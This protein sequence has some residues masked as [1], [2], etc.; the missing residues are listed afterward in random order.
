M[1]RRK[2][3]AQAWP[4]ALAAAPPVFGALRAGRP[5]RARSEKMSPRTE[6]VKRAMLAMQRDAWEQGTAAQALLEMGETE[7]VILMAKEAA[8]RQTPDG[9]LAVL[10]CFGGVTDPAANG[11][12][13]LFAARK[14]GDPRLFQAA[15]KMLSYLLERAP[16]RADGTLYH[17]SDKKQVWIDSLYMAPPFLA[18]AGRPDEAVRQVEGIRRV[19]WNPEA[20]LFSQI[21]DDDRGEFERKDFWGVGNGWAAA[22]MTR[23]IRALPETM[24]GEKKALAGHV[25]EVIDG[26]LRRQRDDGLFHDVLDRP[27]TFVETNLAQMLAYSIYRGI[28]GGWLDPALQKPADRMREAARGKVDAF[29][30]VQGVCGSPE[31]S[32]AGTATEGQAFFLLMET[33]AAD[34]A[35]SR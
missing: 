14:T 13:M 35:D 4:A 33:A 22:G 3:L 31:F 26:C 19:L 11:E 7:E 28:A 5:A 8:V 18:V 24:T 10:S 1:K 25:R 17:V 20:G 15:E 21:W 6:D 32:S 29:G 9:R 12:A 30:L 27:D 2:F 34:L 16:R 23:V